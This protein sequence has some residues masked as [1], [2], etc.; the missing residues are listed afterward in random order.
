[1]NG[2]EKRYVYVGVNVHF[3]QLLVGVSA[4][5]HVSGNAA[6]YLMLQLLWLWLLYPIISRHVVC[7]LGQYLIIYKVNLACNKSWTLR[8]EMKCSASIL[9]LTFSKTRVP[10]S[11]AQRIGRTLPPRKFLGTHFC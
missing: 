6:I 2:T 7:R 8:G 10:E 3:Y 4:L 9:T 5:G 1:M 11:S